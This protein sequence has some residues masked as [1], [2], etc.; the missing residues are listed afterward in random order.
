MEVSTQSH[1]G[2][3]RRLPTSYPLKLQDNL[4]LG[5]EDRARNRGELPR[6]FCDYHAF[7]IGIPGKG[8]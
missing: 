1:N 6:P 2:G 7:P 4:A 5:L 3:A 8:V